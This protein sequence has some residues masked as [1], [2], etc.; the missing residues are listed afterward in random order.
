MRFGATRLAK[1][2]AN[3]INLLDA[4]EKRKYCSHFENIKFIKI[5]FYMLTKPFIK[6]WI[7]SSIFEGKPFFVLFLTSAVFWKIKNTFCSQGVQFC[8]HRNSKPMGI[9]F[10]T[11]YQKLHIKY[12]VIIENDIISTWFSNN[13]YQSNSFSSII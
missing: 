11:F 9:A 8:S 6:G 7:S 2:N 4:I 3:A 12:F 10:N 1:D 13:I 5:F